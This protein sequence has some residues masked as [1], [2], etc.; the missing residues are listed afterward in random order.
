MSKVL[1]TETYLNN[2]G[3][4][5]RSKNGTAN[6]Y[7]PS[8]MANAISAISEANWTSDGRMYL[9]NMTFPSG[10]TAIGFSGDTWPTGRYYN[11]SGIQTVVIPDSVTAIYA[12]AFCDCRNLSNITFGSGLL[13][14][15]NQAFRYT[16]IT[17]LDL[18][19]TQITS[20]GTAAFYGCRQ[21]T[22]LSLPATITSINND[23]NSATFR[24]CFALKTV[25]LGNG[26]L[27]SINFQW[28]TQFTA[29]DIVAMFNKLGNVPTGETRTFTLGATNL[30]KLTDAQKQIATDKGWT[31]A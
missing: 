24:D 14:I 25:N 4:A 1:V 18:S 29:D 21:L 12:G 15:G 27:C 19:S 16:K 8:Q 22:T 23:V 2:I 5:I 10:T 28:S 6:R 9:E 20:L 26:F 13:T 7:T 30:A 11:I 31:L 3:A 17:T